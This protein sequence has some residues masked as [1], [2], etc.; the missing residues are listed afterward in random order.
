MK[1]IIVSLC[2]LAA[3][4]WLTS[5]TTPQEDFNARGIT[6]IVQEAVDTTY[7]TRL[8]PDETQSIKDFNH[9]MWV[10]PFEQDRY[11]HDVYVVM[12]KYGVV[13]PIIDSFDRDLEWVTNDSLGD[14]FSEDGYNAALENGWFHHPGTYLPTQWAGNLTFAMHS[15]YWKNQPGNYKTIGQAVARL[16]V[17]DR[18]FLYIRD[19]A[20]YFRLYTYTVTSSYRT[21][22]SDVSIG[23][24]NGWHELTTYVCEPFGTAKNRWVI[25]AFQDYSDGW[26]LA[27]GWKMF[28]D[29]AIEQIYQTRPDALEFFDDVLWRANAVM[30]SFNSMRDPA[31]KKLYKATVSYLIMRMQT[32]TH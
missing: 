16:S 23:T 31:K 13:A 1:K 9:W 19:D 6:T 18:I 20:D 21:S 11:T 22:A 12:P 26:M 28:L 25:K 14:V 3:G 5:A 7:P 27:D 4:M 17:W 15:S 24:H 10:L 8:Q 32:Y 2:V 30:I 29:T